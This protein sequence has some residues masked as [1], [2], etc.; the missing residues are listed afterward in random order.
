MEQAFFG[1]PA[2]QI[3]SVGVSCSVMKKLFPF[4][5]HVVLFI[6]FWSSIRVAGH[7]IGPLW[8][9]RQNTT[10]V[11]LSLFALMLSLI[12]LT[13]RKMFECAAGS[14]YLGL[15][16]AWSF[17]GVLGSDG[18]EGLFIFFGSSLFSLPFLLWLL[19]FYYIPLFKA[20]REEAK[21]LAGPEKP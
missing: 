2:C 16:M 19:I 12:G 17:S 10:I 20:W 8:M 5:K 21:Q 9:E 18:S 4:L 1:C 11:G 15:W 14:L 7:G 13:G 3:F 6:F